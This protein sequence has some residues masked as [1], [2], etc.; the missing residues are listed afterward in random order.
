MKKGQ[1]TIQ[2]T[3]L[4][5]LVMIFSMFYA[6]SVSAE[7]LRIFSYEVYA[8]AEFQQKF[9]KLVK[10][11]YDIDL[12]LDIKYINEPDE[13]FP[14]LRDGKADIITPSHNL[15]KDERYQLIK[16]KLALPLNLENIPNYKNVDPGLQK[17]DYCSKGDKVYAVP[18]ARGPYGLAY[19]TTILK[20]APE[21]WNIFW[22][23]QFKDKYSLGEYQYEENIFNAALAMG[24]SPK[25]MSNYKKLNTPEFQKKLAYLVANAHGM[26]KIQDTPKD[27]KGLPFA[28]SWGDSLGGLK[29]MGEIW[30][31]AEPKEGTTFWVDNVMIG[32]TLENKPKLK[33]IAEE[34]LNI[35][36]SDEYQLNVVTRG[37]GTIP[38]ITTIMEHLTPDEIER[39]HL[40]DPTYF[41]DNSI[42]W[43]T[44]GKTDRKGL[45][46]LWKKAMK[47]RK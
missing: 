14:M 5:V 25:D 36:L 21:S 20:K 10:E 2:C 39:C 12:K 37:I 3:F 35:V 24:F 30:K 38:V 4:L 33:Q 23:P 34:W 26:W 22:E 45:K 43:P 44:L 19:N 17:A 40:D 46:R 13:I 42:L 6:A 8:S 41:T 9:I 29:E 32:Y 7:T 15:P 31:M 27:L 18:V 47:S 16:H 11:K 28:M 1:M